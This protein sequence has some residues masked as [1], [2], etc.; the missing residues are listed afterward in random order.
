MI[1]NIA[2]MTGHAATLRWLAQATVTPSIP[3]TL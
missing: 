3:A 1:A 2:D